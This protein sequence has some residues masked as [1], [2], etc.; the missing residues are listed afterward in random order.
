ML[1]R[2]LLLLRV[3]ILKIIELSFSEVEVL[4]SGKLNL[5]L[6][7]ATEADI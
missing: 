6:P 2:W 4:L 3:E 5:A 7:V 1:P